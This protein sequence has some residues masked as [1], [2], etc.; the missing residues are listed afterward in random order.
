MAGWE[1]LAESDPVPGDP[2]AVAGLVHRLD[3]TAEVMR[4]Q[5]ERM[6]GIDA[7]S[8]W[9]G[10]AAE[11][12]ARHQEELPPL[13]DRLVERYARVSAALA[14]YHPS[15]DEAQAMAR[16]ALARA[17]V[18]EADITTAERGLEA[19]EQHA[20]DA[21]LRADQQTAT[22]PPGSPPVEPEP[23]AGPNWDAALVE[24]KADMDAARRLLDD[25]KELRDEAAQRATGEI[26]AAIDDDLK[27]EVGFF[28]ALRRGAGAIVEALPVEEFAQV[29]GVVAGVLA[30]AALAF[31]VLAPIALVAG[32]LSLLATATLATAGEASWGAVGLEVIG[33]IGVGRVFTAMS[34]AAR[35]TAAARAAATVPKGLT[36]KVTAT[37]GTKVSGAAARSTL[38]KQYGRVAGHYGTEASPGLR[39]SFERGMSALRPRSMMDQYGDDMARLGRDPVGAMRQSFGDQV[40]DLRGGISPALEGVPAIRSMP[41]LS[42]DATRLARIGFAADVGAAS[43]SVV[44]AGQNVHDWMTTDMGERGAGVRPIPVVP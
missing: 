19:M 44:S 4:D 20:Q 31:P 5:T 29:M 6:R 24:A 33:L 36:G 28:V 1:P 16:Q 32:G 30:I 39:R 12:F 38:T 14:A 9:E 27:N 13:L 22:S 42:R 11:Q 25:A 34:R 15:L 2:A 41:D 8:F 40:A 10:E 37:T 17:R 7:K 43:P 35:G 26:D 18:A 3:A 23:W 21:R